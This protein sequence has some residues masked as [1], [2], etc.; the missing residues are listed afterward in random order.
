MKRE[1]ILQLENIHKAFSDNNDKIIKAVN[2]VNIALGKGECIGIVGESGCGKS[3]LARIIAQ[4]TAPSEGKIIYRGEDITALPKKSTKMYYKNVQMIFQDPLGTFSPRMKI[5]GYL[6]E[7]FVNFKIMSKNK[8]HQYAEGLLEK[9]GLSKDY[10]KKYPNELSGGE[11]QRVV[12]ARAIGL[13]PDIILCDECTSALDVSIQKQIIA[14]LIALKKKTSFSSIFI[15]HDLALA[16]S[17]CDKIYVMY[18]GEIVE[19]LEGQNLVREARHPYTRML[20]DS[21]FSIKNF[22]KRIEVNRKIGKALNGTEGCVFAEGCLNRSRRCLEE[23]PHLVKVDQYVS[24]ACR[25]YE[26]IRR[27][28]SV[29]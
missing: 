5:G 22:D 18:L 2:N 3:T 17:I 26:E 13:E 15:T 4:L 16:E 8:A 19:V 11:L 6:I 25:K 1:I 7:P 10:M 23:K 14:L 28:P 27:I 9:V 29:V 20:L 24:V 12:I 21:V